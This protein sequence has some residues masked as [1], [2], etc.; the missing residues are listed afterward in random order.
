[1]N[2]YLYENISVGLIEKFEK[3]ITD[4]MLS[5]FRTITGDDNPLHTD[6][7]YAQ[8]RGFNDKVIYGM[9]SASLLSTLAGVYLPGKYSLIYSTKINF[10]KPVFVGDTISVSGTVK[11]KDDRFN[12]IRLKIIMGNQDREK[13]LSGSMQIGVTE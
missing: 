7:E 1:M 10:H 12:I 9:L 11:E 2:S 6:R 13:V 4:E 5:G 8:K 3:T